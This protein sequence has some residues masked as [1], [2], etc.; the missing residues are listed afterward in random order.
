MN[1]YSRNKWNRGSFEIL[2]NVTNKITEYPSKI[3]K[4]IFVNLKT[5]V[6]GSSRTETFNT[7]E[8]TG[9]FKLIYLP[10]KVIKN[11]SKW[12]LKNS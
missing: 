11:V 12:I 10:F 5:P 3:L 9:R 7:Q 8:D 1:H 6:N 2:G 4:P